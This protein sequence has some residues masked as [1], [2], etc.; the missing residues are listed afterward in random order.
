MPK[1]PFPIVYTYDPQ[2]ENE[3]YAV[4]KPFALVRRRKDYALITDFHNAF[5]VYMHDCYF[6]YPAGVEN[7]G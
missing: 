3:N 4:I 1:N 6:D 2:C 5:I 7:V